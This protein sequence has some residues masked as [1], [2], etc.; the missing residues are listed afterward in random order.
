MNET[1][2]KVYEHFDEFQYWDRWGAL[3]L[4]L[5]QKK[6][7]KKFIQTYKVGCEKCSHEQNS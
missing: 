7:V 2:K 5:A 3:K 1:N 4:G 6:D